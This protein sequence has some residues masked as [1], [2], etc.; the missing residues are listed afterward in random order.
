MRTTCLNNRIGFFFKVRRTENPPKNDQLQ[1]SEFQRQLQ[2]QTKGHAPISTIT[3]DSTIP[4]DLEDPPTTHVA[5]ASGSVA[6]DGHYQH[7]A[8]IAAQVEQ[9]RP[10]EYS[11]QQ[12]HNAQDNRSEPSTLEKLQKLTDSDL[13]IRKQKAKEICNKIQVLLVEDN[14]INQRILRRKLEAKGFKVTTANNG[15]EA[16]EAVYTVSEA[17]SDEDD[18]TATIFDVILMDQEMPILDGNSATKAI[19]ELEREG[20]V[21]H[22]P[23]LGVTANVREEQK[24]EM[25]KAGMDDVI[26]KPYGIEEMVERIKKLT[27][28]TGEP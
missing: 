23:I 28:E 17:V 3:S 6:K 16:V 11:V 21:L 10:D 4:H 8:E 12:R 24:D 14:I 2:E 7:T 26:S 15:R 13:S 27:A 9:P 1:P 19:R 22:V 5:E 20:L 25:K 18:N